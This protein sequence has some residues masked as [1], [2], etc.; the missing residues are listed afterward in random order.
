MQTVVIIALLMCEYIVLI[1]III[2]NLAEVGGSHWRVI[3]VEVERVT[4]EKDK[5]F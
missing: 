5:I 2:F 1:I 3:E 4:G